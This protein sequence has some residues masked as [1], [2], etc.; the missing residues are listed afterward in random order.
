MGMAPEVARHDPPAA[1]FAGADGLD[2]YRAILPDLPRLLAPGG[3]AL[4]EIGA[5]Q[6]ADIAGI[7]RTAGLVVAEVRRDLAG[8]DRWLTLKI[9]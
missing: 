6:A 9:A 8:R 7:A 3:T 2:A 4:F 5:T 1:L